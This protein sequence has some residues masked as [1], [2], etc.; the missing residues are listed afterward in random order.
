MSIKVYYIPSDYRDTVQ[1]RIYA[2]CKVPR[3]T[4]MDR[5]KS[6]TENVGRLIVLTAAEEELMVERIKL[7]RD[8][9]YALD[10]KTALLRQGLL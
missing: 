7:F 8:W 5:L 6:R 9:G 10:N 1:T 4:L 3:V 2:I